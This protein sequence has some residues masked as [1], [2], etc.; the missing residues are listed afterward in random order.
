MQKRQ[1]HQI[2]GACQK[3]I[4]K[5]HELGQL[6]H[7][8]I[9]KPSGNASG[10]KRLGIMQIDCLR[11]VMQD[12]EHLTADECE[13]LSLALRQDAAVLPNGSDKENLLKLAE[14]YRALA[15]AKRVVLR[16]VN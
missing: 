4:G 2:G 11:P 9:N 16:N 1:Q 15:N 3:C 14:G 10:R 5:R 6:A 8:G 7:C 12:D 13:E